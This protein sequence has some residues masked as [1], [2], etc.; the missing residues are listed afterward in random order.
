MPID[1]VIPVRPGDLNPE[2][3]YM[4]RTLE[5]NYPQHGNIWVVGYQPRWLTNVNF[6]PGNGFRGNR[7]VYMNVLAAA[8]HPDVPDEFIVTNDDIMITTP[9][10]CI[11]VH[12]HGS[13]TAQCAGVRRNPKTWWHRSLLLTLD[14]LRKAGYPDPISYEV[15][16]PLPVAKAGMAEVLRRFVDVAPDTPPQWRTLYGV[17]ND[18]GGTQLADP[19][20]RKRG[21]I[22]TPYHST[23]DS[24]FRYF[25]GYFHNHYPTPSRYEK[26]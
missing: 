11:D 26:T 8:E 22:K 10:E 1:I 15:H 19:K 13:L 25:R 5:V 16:T 7:N 6:I 17:V 9:L 4:L 20:A 21:P 3:Q 24:S 14:T 18:I 12:H 23:E 2:L